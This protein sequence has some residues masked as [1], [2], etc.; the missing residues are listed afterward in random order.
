VRDPGEGKTVLI[1]AAARGIGRASARALA[2]AGAKV[3]ATDINVGVLS[4]ISGENGIDT[5]KLNVLDDE[6]IKALVAGI[7]VVDV[8]FNCAGVVHNGS[9]VEMQDRDSRH[10]SR[11]V[12]RHPG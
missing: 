8:R 12:R 3:H 1:T 7:G 4:Q 5:H 9:I 10:L 2:K 11:I 6:E